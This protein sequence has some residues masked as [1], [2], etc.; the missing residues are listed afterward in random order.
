[1]QIQTEKGKGNGAKSKIQGRKFAKKDFVE[2]SVLAAYIVQQRGEASIKDVQSAFKENLNST[3]HISTLSKVLEALKSKDLLAALFRQ[4][5]R[6]FKMKRVKFNCNVEVAHVRKLIPTLMD[7]PAGI[8]IK[9]EI[10]GVLNDGK[11][12]TK[13]RNLP[14]A[15]ANYVVEFKL[16]T[17]W[18]GS[19][20]LAGN[21]LLALAYEASEFSDTFPQ[22]C[23]PAMVPLLFER[24]WETKGILI[25]NACVRGFFRE[26]L[27]SLELSPWSVNKIYAQPITHTPK[28]IVIAKFPIQTKQSS[29]ARTRY[30]Y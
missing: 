21:A 13:D 14:Q 4:E 12:G 22:D 30:Y 26:H 20:V 17:P 16:L 7:D 28:K 5:E 24:D 2:L 29:R 18:L 23:D 25:H 8:A 15:W 11:S 19:Q 3:V 6:V 1:M 9:A 27:T 10:E